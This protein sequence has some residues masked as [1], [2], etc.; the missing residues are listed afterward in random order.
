LELQNLDNCRRKTK[1]FGSPNGR[2]G[3]EA[4]GQEPEQ[5]GQEIE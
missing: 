4:E 2:G 5:I 1:A 3:E